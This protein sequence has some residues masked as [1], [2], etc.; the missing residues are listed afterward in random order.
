[1]SHEEMLMHVITHSDGHRRQVSALMLLNAVPPRRWI[2][3]IE[4]A[5]R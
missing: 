3:L 1:M 5:A 4:R 2:V